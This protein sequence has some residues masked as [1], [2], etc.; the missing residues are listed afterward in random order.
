[1][2]KFL[3]Q[4]RPRTLKTMTVE[5]VAVGVVVSLASV[6]LGFYSAAFIIAEKCYPELGVETISAVHRQLFYGMPLAMAV[7]ALSVFALYWFFA[8]GHVK[9][10]ASLMK[11][12]DGGD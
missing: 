12:P 5:Y 11:Q 2:G 8:R 10:M 1:M 4:S 7:Y 9:S 6:L 3:G